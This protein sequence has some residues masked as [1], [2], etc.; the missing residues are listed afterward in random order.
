MKIT[1]VPFVDLAAR[2]GNGANR[3][4]RRS[5]HSADPETD[6]PFRG[7]RLSWAEFYA[8]RPD[9]RPANDNGKAA[10][11]DVDARAA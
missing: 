7:R 4:G 6:H 2:L 10:D 1:A 5:H 11:R 9:L 8:L 3:A